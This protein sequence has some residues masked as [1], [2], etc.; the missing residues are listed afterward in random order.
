MV[1]YCLKVFLTSTAP[2][3]LS[4]NCCPSS[5]YD[6]FSCNSRDQTW[7][8]RI[9]T[10]RT[11]LCLLSSEA[12]IARINETHFERAM[13]T[14]PGDVLSTIGESKYSSRLGSILFPYRTWKR[15]PNTLW[16]PPKVGARVTA[17]A[18]TIRTI[19]GRLCHPQK[20][21]C[22]FQI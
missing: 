10:A 21:C 9:N 16:Q 6:G 8:S 4:T 20:S 19:G 18:P 1:R 2:T 22:I 5:S 14:T 17:L 7:T 11:S 12:S 13:R 3:T 15:V